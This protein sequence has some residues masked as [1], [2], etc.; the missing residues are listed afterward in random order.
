MFGY[1]RIFV[2]AAGV[3]VGLLISSE[4]GRELRER[5]RAQISGR[6]P[7]GAGPLD[8]RVRRE[9]SHSPRTWHLPQPDIEVVGGRVVLHGSVPHE[10]GRTDLEAA[11]RAVH[12]VTTVD[13]RLVIA[14]DT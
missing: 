11:A 10:T 3:G 4:P 12:G 14:E 7:E 13:N 5:I 8:E 9:L 1:R 2:F 6:E